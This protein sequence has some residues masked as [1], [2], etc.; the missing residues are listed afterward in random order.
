VFIGLSTVVMGCGH[1]T[2]N[3][4]TVTKDVTLD[5]QSP[6]N[7]K[8]NPWAHMNVKFEYNKVTHVYEAWIPWIKANSGYYF[9][10]SVGGK[11][12]QP[13]LQYSYT[14]GSTWISR[15]WFY[16][17]ELQSFDLKNTSSPSSSVVLKTSDSTKLMFQ[18]GTTGSGT[19]ETML[20]GYD[21]EYIMNDF[22]VTKRTV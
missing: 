9:T 19:P 18:M 4:D 13:H 12:K 6:S 20:G 16:S 22:K 1:S 2:A 17:N 3:T 15:S 8:A 21:V 5:F 11:D 10:A 14:Q 7:G